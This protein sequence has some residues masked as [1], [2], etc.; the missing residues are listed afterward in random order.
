MGCKCVK[1][2]ID[3]KDEITSETKP[4]KNNHESITNRESNNDENGE[5][6]KNLKQFLVDEKNNLHQNHDIDAPITFDDKK[7]DERSHLHESDIQ[8]KLDN[9]NNENDNNNEYSV[10]NNNEINEKNDNNNE[11][12]EKNDNNNE[13]NEKNDNNNEINEKNEN[14]NEINEYNENNNDNNKNE[15]ESE[16][17]SIEVKNEDNDNIEHSDNNLEPE[18]EFSKY[19]FEKINE[20]RTNPKNFISLIEESKKNI[21]VDKKDRLIY[22]SKVKV[23]LSKGLPIFEEAISFLQETEPMNQLIYEPKITIPVP[24]NEDDIKNK[25]YLKEKVEEINNNYN[26]QT[27]WRDIIKDAE[28]SFILMIV[29]D[30]GSK[31]GLKRKDI[32]NPDFKYI[33]ISSVQIDKSFV[34][35]MTFS[36]DYKKKK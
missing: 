25:S 1:K 35:Y 14:N 9:K 22:K 12:N 2:G 34:C 32:L 15:F 31:S 36:D 3:N 29:D 6:N 26:I 13:I 21:T 18:D 20:V 19:I 7:E 17:N 5:K 28:T 11:I 4:K 8:N 27:Y 24:D 30:T 33:G 16:K 23:A 10:N